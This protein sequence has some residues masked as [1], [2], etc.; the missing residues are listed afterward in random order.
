MPT[1]SIDFQAELSA[2]PFVSAGTSGASATSTAS[3]PSSADQLTNF[4]NSVNALLNQIPKAPIVPPPGQTA[5]GQDQWKTAS[6]SDFIGS[7]I[8]T[9]LKGLS[10]AADTLNKVVSVLEKVLQ[11]ISLFINGFSSF[12][13]LIEASLNLAERNLSQIAPYDLTSGVYAT[14]VA[15]E[16]FLNPDSLDASQKSRG[17]FQGFISQLSISLANTRDKNRPTFGVDDSVGGMVILVDSNSLDSIYIALKQ[18]RGMFDFM[19]LFGINM[20]P[21][22]PKNLS[23]SC[24]FFKTPAGQNQYGVK[25][26][27]DNNYLSSGFLISRSRIPGGTKQFVT[28]IPSYLMD[29]EETGE[30]GLIT[31]VK[32]WFASTFSKPTG[33]TPTQEDLEKT[34][35]LSGDP[36]IVGDPLTLPE[37]LET[38]YADPFFNKGKPKLVGN[39]FGTTLEFIDTD[40]VVSNNVPMV[41]DNNGTLVPV[42]ELYY[43]IQSCDLN[44]SIKGPFSKELVVAIKTC[45]DAYNTTDV[46]FYPNGRYKVLS[47]DGHARLNTWSSIQTNFIIPWVADINSLLKQLI[48]TMRGMTA[49]ASSSFSDFILQIQAN[50]QRWV[51]LINAISYTIQMLQTFILGPTISFLEVPP[52]Q[53][54][55]DNFVKRIQNAKLPPGSPPFSGANGTSIGFVLTYGAKKDDKVLANSMAQAFHFIATLFTK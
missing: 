4:T 2:F 7:Q 10:K 26:Q 37:A 46:I 22:P 15:P 28:F 54:G 38:V 12:S 52:K 36:F 17:G 27:W 43:V 18:L 5:V 24:G 8:Q 41:K 30:P 19:K 44:A 1:S 40:I 49:N 45:N 47:I 32:K 53:G 11:I 42:S 34:A 51:G 39:S 9:V 23:G 33:A 6:V 31:V 16:A 20:L 55:M 35:L 13:K 48:G 25:L 14:V 21:P 3:A 29:N 50:V